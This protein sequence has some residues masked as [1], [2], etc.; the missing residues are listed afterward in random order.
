MSKEQATV[1]AATRDFLNPTQK[2]AIEEIL[3]SRD[4]IHGLQGLAGTG[5]TTTLE[6]I[7]EGAE[8]SGFIV[9]GFAPTSRAA[10]QLRDA[11]IDA[12]TLQSFLAKH[13]DID[14]DKK[15]LY[16]VD[17]SSLTSTRQMHDFLEK[18]GPQDRV[19]LIGDTSQHQGV[20]AGKPFEQMQAAGMQTS[21]LDK[22]M[23]QKDPEL[24]KA[25]EH[26]SKNETEQGVKLLASQGRITE[27]ADPI[28]RI[29]A[30]AKD[31]AHQPENTLIVSPDNKSRQQINE[32]IRSELQTAGAVSK[33]NHTVSTLTQRSDMTGADRTW[34][35]RYNAGDILQYTTGSK[36][37]GIERGSYA[38]V[39]AVNQ[40]ENQITVQRADGQSVTY[41][42]K[43]LQGI[44]AF[45]ETSREFAQGDRVQFTGINR[46]LGVSNRD[47]GTITKIEDRQFSVK[48]DG[49]KPREIN[50]ESAQMRHLDHGYAVTSH[51]SQGL[52]TG[53]VLVNMD[54]TT[55]A[56]LIN[57]RF[58]YV[59]ISRASQDA[60]IYTNDAAHLG[61]RLA[62]N[63]SKSSAVEIEAKPTNIKEKVME[64]AYTKAEEHRHQAPI[65]LT[66]PK[67]APQFDWKQEHSNGTQSYQHREALGWLH[68][69]PKGQCHDPDGRN[70]SPMLALDKATDPERYQQKQ[71]SQDIGQGFSA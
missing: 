50:F 21:Q 11:K 68:I 7:R 25:V 10:G 49:D 53:R 36:E 16:M 33:D 57:S 14:P 26:L 65:E 45:R 69:D 28:Q 64:T 61:E 8:K 3:T 35:S 24:L 54:T 42:P 15:H 46:E 51:S 71:Q 39:T 4:L 41:D 47:L 60:R 34:A 31:Y 17:E 19:L 29:D 63:V 13:Q 18:I 12:G 66:F 2:N 56:E 30:I 43:R 32:A 37:H 38:T 9:E 22:I 48:M 40:K 1:Q 55:H 59:S 52:T 23:R 67:E 6:S 62:T 5:K 20:D 44:S 70:I 27:I 58:A